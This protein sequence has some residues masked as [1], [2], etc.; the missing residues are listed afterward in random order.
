MNDSDLNVTLNL[1]DWATQVDLNQEI[2]DRLLSDS[3]IGMLSTG[4]SSEISRSVSTD[5]SLETRISSSTNDILSGENY[6]CERW[7]YI[8]SKR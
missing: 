1:N 6:V 5:N 4:L 3:N 7:W 2:Q 8:Y